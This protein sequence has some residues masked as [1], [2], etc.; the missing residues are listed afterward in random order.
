MIDFFD[1][2]GFEPVEHDYTHPERHCDNIAD[3]ILTEWRE[4]G[5]QVFPPEE[6]PIE[7]CWACG[8]TT[9][10][11]YTSGY[12]PRIK[13]VH[14]R[15]NSG[16]WSIGSKWL[17]KDEP[18]DEYR[19]NEHI[20]WKFLKEQ[21]GLDIPLVKEMIP[22]SDPQETLQFTLISRAQG[23]M[24]SAIWPK[25][26]PEQ[27]AGYRDQMVHI[28]KQLRQFTAPFP[29]KVNGDKLDDTIM[30]I[31]HRRS[32]PTCFKVGHTVDEWLEDLSETLRAGLADRLKTSDEK[33][34]EERLQKIKDNFP[35]G[36]PYVL[37]HGDLA[38]RNI[39]VKDDKIVAILDW[40][41]AGYY[42]W[43]AEKYAC[44]AYARIEDQQDL[45][46]G[47]WE[48]VDPE[49][50]ETPAWRAVVQK[51]AAVREAM[52][53]F[54][55]KHEPHVQPLYRAP[56]CKCR[57]H[58]QT[59][60]PAARGDKP[61]HKLWDWRSGLKRPSTWASNSEFIIMG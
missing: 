26:S 55:V 38:L 9:Y 43:W 45:F 54:V 29:Q 14:A 22:L 61:E 44:K 6:G 58:G 53:P 31:C 15:N 51:V 41:S 7:L 60:R 36:E 4:A 23:K 8:W 42:P 2:D 52:V 19:G 34:V 49:L 57:P 33:V 21:P 13:I 5:Y 37:T 59:I 10:D 40:E 56:F 32:S 17:I 46:E 20:T 24:L 12:S 3:H 28:L 27:K 48:R 39:M 35:S 30:G 16:L 1:E 50:G 18:N 11:Q 25:L 47:V